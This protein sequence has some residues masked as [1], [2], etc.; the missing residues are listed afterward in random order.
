ME[1]VLGYC[2]IFQFGND[3]KL[4]KHPQPPPPSSKLVFGK[5]LFYAD[6]EMSHGIDSHESACRISPE[7]SAPA[8]KGK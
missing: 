7:S 6:Y 1:P 8:E 3:A 2:F 4:L 5:L